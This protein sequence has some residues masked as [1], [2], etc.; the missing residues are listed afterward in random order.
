MKPGKCDS[1]QRRFIARRVASQHGVGRQLRFIRAL[2]VAGFAVD[3]ASLII[4][5]HHSLL[6]LVDAIDATAKLHTSQMHL[7]QSR[8]HFHDG[9]IRSPFFNFQPF[10]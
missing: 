2:A 7:L 5:Q 6:Y 1:G 8:F 4:Q 9:E 10:R 3:L